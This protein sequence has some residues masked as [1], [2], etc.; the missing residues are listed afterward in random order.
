MYH[1]VHTLHFVALLVSY[2]SHAYPTDTTKGSNSVV[3]RDFSRSV[4]ENYLS[5]ACQV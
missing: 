5:D 4:P 1:I 3:A 2:Q